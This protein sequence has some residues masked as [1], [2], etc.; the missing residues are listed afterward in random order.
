MLEKFIDSQPIVYNVLINQ[1]RNNN[2]GHAYLFVEN[3]NDDFFDIIMAFVKEILCFDLDN[4]EKNIMCER[5]DAGNYPEIKIISPDGMF[6]KK[7]QIMDLQQDFS[8]TA[9]EGK[10]RIYIIRDVDKMRPETANSMLKFLEEPDNDIMAILVTNNINNVL[11]TIISRCQVIRLNSNSFKVINEE[12][13]EEA[14]N[15][16]ESIELKNCSAIITCQSLL[17]NVIANKDRDV[18]I[19]FFDKIIDLYYDIM[20][21][22]LGL[23]SVKYQSLRERLNKISDINTYYSV[24]KKID[25]L[26]KNKDSIKNNVN[27]NLFIDNIIIGIGGCN[28]YSRC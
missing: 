20:K 22:S 23:N 18:L 16:I 28:E 2:L 15:F 13:L 1:I 17:T 6:I 26:V 8:M 11:Q 9:I 21:I 14:I 27:I 25:F 5:I 12:Y 19:M 7:K 10:K 4:N 3:V 24:L